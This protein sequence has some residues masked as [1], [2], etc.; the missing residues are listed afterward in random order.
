LVAAVAVAAIATAVLIALT[1]PQTPSA[2][3][4]L[5]NPN[6]YDSFVQ[7]GNLILGDVSSFSDLD[8]EA[9]R[10]LVSSNAEPLR[11][12]RLGLTR[13]CSFQPISQ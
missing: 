2:N 10:G 11:L 13:K 6:G 4:A 7:A 1:F 3:H 8:H 5:P 12:L 9:L